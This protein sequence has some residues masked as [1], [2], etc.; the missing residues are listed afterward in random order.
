MSHHTLIL[1]ESPRAGPVVSRVAV[2]GDFLATGN[3]SLPAGGWAEAAHQLRGHFDDV[4]MAFVNLECVLD[5]EGLSPRQLSGLGQIISAPAASLGYLE[6]VQAG[7]VSLANNHS[8]DFGGAGV[9][10]T[11]R[12]LTQRGLVPLGAGRALHAVPEVFLWQGPGNIRVGF[13]AAATASSDLATRSSPGVEPATFHRASQ[14]IEVLK[15]RGA[16]YSIA[17]LHTGCMRTNR[18]DPG[19]V[20]RMDSI[21]K[22]GFGIVAAAHSHR[23]SGAKVLSAERASPFFCF[24]GLGSIVSGDVASPF[25]R[26][27][28]IVV[29]GLDS[30]GGLA[31]VEVRPVMLD[32]TGF[33]EVPSPEMSGMVLDRF[34]RLSDEITGGSSERLFYRDVSP[35]L[36]RLHMRDA[37]AA[38]R[39]SG[40]RGLA[41][42]A[43][44]VRMRHLRRLVHR[45]IG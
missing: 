14:A 12:A 42:K 32:E 26:E 36:V 15:S 11:R 31:R 21:A 27:G 20:A 38:F 24:Y 4:A 34:R 17:L 2:A 44:R 40:V 3:L 1:W 6:A 41:R 5:A 19:D 37:R 25:E 23:I 39:Q 8:Y 28:L 18:P 13:W 22:S 16:Q 7:V 33:G 29:A 10:R 43:A 30:S 35:G 45:V 9:E